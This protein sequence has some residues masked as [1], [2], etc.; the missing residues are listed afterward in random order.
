MIALTRT[1]SLATLA[2]QNTIVH[3]HHVGIA[4]IAKGTIVSVVPLDHPTKQT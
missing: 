4:A 3:H 1:I 2:K